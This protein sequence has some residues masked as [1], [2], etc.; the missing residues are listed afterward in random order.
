NLFRKASL[1]QSKW[2][3]CLSMSTSKNQQP[4]LANKP[5]FWLI[6]SLLFLGFLWLFKSVLMPF[7]LGFAIAYLLNPVIF[8]LE[9]IKIARKPASLLILTSFFLVVALILAVISPLLI[10]EMLEFAEELPTYT[11]KVWALAQPVVERIQL[12]LG[13]ET[14]DDLIAS[15]KPHIGKAAQTSAG[16]LKHIVSGGLAVFDFTL[17]FFLTPIVAYFLLKEW[18]KITKWTYDLMPRDHEKTLKTLLSDIDKKISGFV[19]GQLSVCAVLG[20]L[21]AVALVI[22]GLKY[23]FFIGLMAGA[24]SIIPLVGSVVGLLVS[25]MVAWFQSGDIMF[26]GIIAAIFLVGQIVEGN[27]LTPKLVGDS[28]GL[29]PLW[30][31]F[32]LMAGG[33]LLGILGMLIAVPVTAIAG[34]LIGFGLTKYRASAFYKKEPTKKK[35]TKK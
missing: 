10:R 33:A 30:V 19:R 4:V 34:V 21:Y 3:H 28:V 9:K 20:L 32:A 17:T 1:L 11:D 16:I 5:L 13:M 23:G 22:A 18:P 29:H 35:S 6:M 25:V 26:V 24:L 8:K 7:V 15:V 12:Q 31:L 2:G 14:S 27:L